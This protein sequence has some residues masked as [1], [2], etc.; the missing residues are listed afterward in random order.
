MN[1]PLKIQTSKEDWGKIEYILVGGKMIPMP[2]LD[3]DLAIERFNELEEIIDVDTCLNC[4]HSE[5]W[6]YSLTGECK[7]KKDKWLKFI[8]VNNVECSLMAYSVVF[9]GSYN[10]CPKHY[11]ED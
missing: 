10:K 2:C 7:L 1:K 5:N 4:K 11:K 8:E 6:D 9:V 3:I